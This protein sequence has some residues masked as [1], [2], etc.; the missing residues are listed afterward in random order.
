[1]HSLH[2]PYCVFTQLPYFSELVLVK[3]VRADFP[4]P[5]VLYH[6]VAVCGCASLAGLRMDCEFMVEEGRRYGSVGW[7][8]VEG[9]A[10]RK[11]CMVGF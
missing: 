2:F 8:L 5:V 7:G 10:D 11:V 9:D 4:L 6:L 3:R 1:M